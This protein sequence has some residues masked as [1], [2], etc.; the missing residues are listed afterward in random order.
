MLFLF[1]YMFSLKITFFLAYNY[2]RDGFILSN[3]LI[4]KKPSRTIDA[5]INISYYR[6]IIIVK[7]SHTNNN[8]KY[9]YWMWRSLSQPTVHTIWMH[10]SIW[11]IPLS[12]WVFFSCNRISLVTYRHQKHCQIHEIMISEPNPIYSS[13]FYL[14]WMA[15]TF[16]DLFLDMLKIVLFTAKSLWFDLKFAGFFCVVFTFNQSAKLDSCNSTQNIND[17][18]FCLRFVS[19]WPA[20]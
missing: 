12:V 9:T 11:L 19:H 18:L 6:F 10:S 1:A 14:F 3:N 4:I 16:D 5:I 7:N 13:Y 2:S 15:I 20:K 17:N 8:N